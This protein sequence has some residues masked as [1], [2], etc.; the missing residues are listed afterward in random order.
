MM[1]YIKALQQ[2]VLLVLTAVAAIALSVSVANAR[3][4][5]RIV[6]WYEM[7]GPAA[8]QVRR[9]A[10]EFNHS[11]SQYELVPEFQGTYDEAVE[12]FLNTHGTR[13]SPALFQSYDISTTQI[14]K[15]GYTVPAAKFIKHDHYDIS[16]LSPAA[17]SF[18]AHRG[19][20]LSMPFNVSQPVMYY[21]R[22]LFQR[23][24][25]TQLPLQPTYSDI[26]RAATQ[27]YQRSHHRIKG[28]SLTPYAWLFEEFYANAN[29][30]FTNHHNG[31][32]GTPTRINYHS[33]VAFTTMRWLQR[34]SKS[35]AF[36]NYGSGNNAFT[37]E[38]AGFLAR[39]VAIFPQSSSDLTQ[40]E[41]GTK[42][43]IGIVDYPRMAGRRVNGVSI[44]GASL[45]IG[46]DKSTKVQRGAW[47]F[48]KFSL[49]PKLQAEW[50]IKTGYLAVNE[51]AFKEP[52]LRHYFAQH[53]EARIPAQQLM[54]TRPNDNNSGI[55]MLNL[56]H[57]RLVTQ[58]MMNRV[59]NGAS[60][61]QSL[62][63]ASRDMVKS[64]QETNR[65]NGE[66]SR[67]SLHSILIIHLLSCYSKN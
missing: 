22:T 65:A 17:M 46:N 30:P 1:R 64:I 66:W 44:G 2:L 25:I 47:D 49:Q 27:V 56:T 34:L 4:R 7:S 37:N 3:K 40:L 20:Q 8:L 50:Q 23:Y 41:A 18:Y 54:N 32:T 63:N 21:N 57:Q 33:S 9:I 59:Y 53:P 35:G 39:K 52:R 45:W 58:G 24:H 26:S 67:W 61:Q 10:H 42:D 12:K 29:E 62:D 36:I 11:Q 14:A 19:K 55:Y 28:L 16:H 5:T 31:H 51:Q 38:I 43:K 48:I 13:T 15:S 6:F 60:I